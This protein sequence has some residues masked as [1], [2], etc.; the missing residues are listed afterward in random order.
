M[1]ARKIAELVKLKPDALT[2]EA[3][4]IRTVER[5]FVE[6]LSK[7][8]E[9][10]GSIGFLLR[11]T[12][13][14]LFSQD[15]E[16]RGIF[17]ALNKLDREHDDFK[18]LALIKYMQY[19]ASRQEVL[20]SIFSNRARSGDSSA[21]AAFAAG[22]DLRETLLFEVEDAEDVARDSAMRRLVRGETV[23]FDLEPEENLAVILSRHRFTVVP[24]RRVYFLDENG[25]DY[26]LKQGRNLI[27]REP[28]N[29][30]IIDPAYRDVSRKH[31]IIEV[32]DGHRVRLTDLSSHGTYVGS[33]REGHDGGRIGDRADV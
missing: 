16:W 4:N 32:E 8:M 17:F 27:G 19:L 2:R 14:K 1:P 18:Q 6:I 23:T 31:L 20:K 3:S 26:A 11:Q 22:S 30:V 24:G 12:D 28:D 25:P 7:S 15:H 29:D 10:T 33:S 9:E 21:A 5:R 13:P